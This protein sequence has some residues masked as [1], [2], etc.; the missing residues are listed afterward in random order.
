MLDAPYFS[1]H[2]LVVGDVRVK[3]DANKRTDLCNESELEAMFDQL[4]VCFK[5]AD[6]GIENAFSSDSEPDLFGLLCDSIRGRL[7]CIEQLGPRCLSFRKLQ[8]VLKCFS[9][10]CSHKYL[11]NMCQIENIHTFLVGS[12][13]EA[14][15]LYSR[16]LQ[17]T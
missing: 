2:D 9:N 3:R 13:P 11:T 10:I 6:A 17:L 8:I 7:V 16:R 4:D 5:K 12:A 15:F 14:S 1:G